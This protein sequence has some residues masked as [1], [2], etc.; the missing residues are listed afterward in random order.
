MIVTSA[1]GR[2]IP[3]LPRPVGEAS[4]SITSRAAVLHTRGHVPTASRQQRTFP[5]RGVR[6]GEPRTE[7]RRSHSATQR[8]PMTS[9]SRTRTRALDC[10]RLVSFRARRPVFAARGSRGVTAAPRWFAPDLLR[11]TARGLA[12]HPVD[13]AQPD[14]APAGG[15]LMQPPAGLAVDGLLAPPPRRGVA[16]RGGALHTSRGCAVPANP[17]HH[18]PAPRPRR[19]SRSRGPRLPGPHAP[20]SPTPRSPNTNAADLS[21]STP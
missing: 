6:C 4:W 17:V 1:C 3:K 7:A 11:Q 21:T 14:R 20:G 19:R 9:S 8:T 2:F 18:H 13:L 5:T 15:S 10:C 12:W 16:P